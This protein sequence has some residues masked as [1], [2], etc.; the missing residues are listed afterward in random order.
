MK[1]FLIKSLS[2]FL[3][4]IM[5]N[6]PA[7]ALSIKNSASFTS[8]EIKAVSEFNDSEVYAAFAELNQLDQYL[9]S[10]ASQSY[11]D[12]AK[13]NST[14]L[15]GV[16]SS[17]TLPLS[18]S[19]SSEKALGIP[20]FLWGCVFGLFGVIFVYIM[21]DNNKEQAKKA[22]FGCVAWSV[23]WVV[24]YVVVIAAVNN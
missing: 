10:N 11:A 19:S 13:E 6:I 20:S 2:V 15:N 12:V 5:L 18:S 17:A 8:S 21:T 1:K 7:F 3:A 9:E 16:S 24:Y 22:F 23:V 14:L 4:F